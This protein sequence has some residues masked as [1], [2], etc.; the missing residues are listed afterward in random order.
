MQ[1]FVL[2]HIYSDTSRVLTINPSQVTVSQGVKYHVPSADASTARPIGASSRNPVP[3]SWLLSSG[4]DGRSRLASQYI[5]AG[6][7]S[8]GAH[9]FA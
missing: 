5:I 1:N 8:K 3:E 7:R 9:G 6:R 4:I 2:E